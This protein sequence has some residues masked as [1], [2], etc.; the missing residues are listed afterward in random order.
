[1]TLSHISTNSSTTMVHI[2]LSPAILKDQL[3]FRSTWHTEA[4]VVLTA[5]ELLHLLKV[6]EVQQNQPVPLSQ[7]AV[8]ALVVTKIIHVTPLMTAGTILAS[9]VAA[10]SVT[11]DELQEV[12][13]TESF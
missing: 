13:S 10:I 7:R 4:V 5:V 8:M 1:M 2:T 9:M 3:S 11:K 12:S 6:L